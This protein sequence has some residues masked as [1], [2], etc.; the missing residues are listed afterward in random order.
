MH[1]A[2]YMMLLD[3]PPKSEVVAL[4]KG[5]KF[6]LRNYHKKVN[7]TRMTGNDVFGLGIY[8]ILKRKNTLNVV[9]SLLLSLSDNYGPSNYS[10]P[11]S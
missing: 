3:V 9:N 8:Y 10:C 6:I 2:L 11:K 1:I 5:A 4:K 7:H